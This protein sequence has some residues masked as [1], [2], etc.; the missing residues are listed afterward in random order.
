MADHLQL[1]GSLFT[2]PNPPAR[3][4]IACGDALPGACNV[5]IHWTVDAKPEHVKWKRGLHV[6]SRSYWAPANIGPYSQAQAISHASNNEDEESALVTVQ[7]AG[8]IPLVP[9]SMVLPS[10]EDMPTS[11]DISHNVD[12][13]SQILL[14]TVLSLQHL[15]RI[16]LEMN[17]IWWSSAV[18]YLRHD[19]L[20]KVAIRAR[21]AG[22]AWSYQHRKPP[23]DEAEDADSS[24]ERDLW[25]ER[26]HG[27]LE[28]RGGLERVR[29]LPDWS[30]VEET[31]IDAVDLAPPFFAAEVIELP[32]GSTVEWHAHLGIAKGPIQLSSSCQEGLGSNYDCTVGNVIRYTTLTIAFQAD[33]KDFT[34]RI[35]AIL[36]HSTK[37]NYPVATDEA[38]FHGAY[39]SY[40]D[41]NVKGLWESDDYSGVIPCQSLW[42]GE[43]K[44]LAA[45]LLF[46]TSIERATTLP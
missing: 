35:A 17:V 3:V 33:I 19:T 21:I 27:G 37:S 42:D 11:L 41:V 12:A 15:W 36:V 39:L 43:G 10:F 46:E 25:E 29:T 4:T 28:N 5:I 24:S 2:E 32:R 34:Q 18:A 6:Q 14:Q 38:G 13:H 20:D 9:A 22:L 7:I 1:Y 40:V 16:G 26:H 45:V 23:S 44:R 8:Q 30:A 31:G